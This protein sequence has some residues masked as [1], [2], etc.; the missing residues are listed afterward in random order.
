MKGPSRRIPPGSGSAP[1]F[2][3]PA[4][5]RAE[6]A[7]VGTIL[8]RRFG[9]PPHHRPEPPLDEL[10]WTLLSQSTTDRQCEEAF[11]SLRRRFPT[12]EDALCARPAQIAVAIRAA[13]LARQ[14]SRRILDILRWVKRRFGALD[15]GFL[16]GM[17]PDEA[18]R[19]LMER[20]G[21]GRKTA[22]VVLLFACGMEVFP[23][24]THILRISRRRGWIPPRAGAD[25]AHRILGGAVPPGMA[26]SL[27][28]NLIGFG[29]RV[30]RA[31]RPTCEACFLARSCPARPAY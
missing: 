17:E 8:E 14:R 12:W 19:L 7:R 29:R 24:D 6:L 2:A 15:L 9:R 3:R 20:P 25:A 5:L 1:R 4:A 27:H 22:Y 16:R 28:L 23:V 18:A 11:R 26:R 21:V 31:Q 10:I 13:G 30:C